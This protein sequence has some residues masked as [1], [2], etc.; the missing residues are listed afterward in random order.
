MSIP[1]SL[2]SMRWAGSDG[3]IQNPWWSG[4]MPAPMGWI[5]VIGGVGYI[6][7]AFVTYAFPSA[8]AAADALAFPAAIG[9]LWM[10]GYLLILGVRRTATS[11]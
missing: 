4:W 3:S 9:E 11:T 1:P 7:G 2:P 8:R 10:V 6:L 5:L